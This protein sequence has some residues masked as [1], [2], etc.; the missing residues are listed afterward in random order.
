MTRIE[1]LLTSIR[2][3]LD[4]DTRLFGIRCVKTGFMPVRDICIRLAFQNRMSFLAVATFGATISPESAYQAI[5]LKGK[6]LG[7]VSEGLK[8][9]VTDALIYAVT[10]LW[11]TEVSTSLRGSCMPAVVVLFISQ[12]PR[13]SVWFMLLKATQTQTGNFEVALC[14][15]QGVKNMTLSRGGFKSL[16]FMLQMRLAWYV[17]NNLPSH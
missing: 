17:S 6:T 7:L 11:L 5:V 2:P 4:C 13:S 16:N 15:A 9:D 1:R 8:N 3:D 10:N 14:H 12:S